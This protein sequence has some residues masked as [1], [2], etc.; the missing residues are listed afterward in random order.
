MKLPKVRE[1]DGTRTAAWCDRCGEEIYE[2]TDF[3][4]VNGETVCE[5]CLCDYARELLALYRQKA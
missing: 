4:R 1:A 2:G 5:D 3:Y